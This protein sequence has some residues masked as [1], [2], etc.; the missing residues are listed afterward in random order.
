ML[1]LPSSL[2]HSVYLP[3][4]LITSKKFQGKNYLMVFLDECYGGLHKVSCHIIRSA[5]LARQQKCLL[6]QT[7]RSL[8]GFLQPEGSCQGSCCKCLR[9]WPNMFSI[10]VKTSNEINYLVNS[11]STFYFF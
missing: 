3:Q 5:V 9:L 1:A 11:N 6:I 10:L 4:Y 7:P 8:F 2:I